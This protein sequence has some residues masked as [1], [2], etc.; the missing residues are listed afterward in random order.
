MDINNILSDSFFTALWI[1]Y[2]AGVATSFTPCIYPLIPVT[3]GVIGGG[4]GKNIKRFFLSLVYVSG[5]SITYAILGVIASLGGKVFGLTAYNPV[6]NFFVAA[7]LI[8]FGL[9]MIGIIKLPLLSGFN[10]NA[11]NYRKNTAGIF[12]MGLVSG[13]VAAPCSTPVL[14]SILAFAAAGGNVPGG[15]LLLFIYGFGSGTLLILAGTFAGILSNLPKSGKWMEI[16]KNIFGILILLAAFYFIL[17]A[18]KAF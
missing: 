8:I 11:D 13:M 1:S 6:V 4:A 7:F 12:V 5:L 17:R 15:A 2:I 18:F 16:V 3:V 9:S 14:G 10:V